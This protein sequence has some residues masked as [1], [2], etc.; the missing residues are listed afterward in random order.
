[1]NVDVRKK[2]E[3][4]REIKPDEVANFEKEWHDNRS[5]LDPRQRVLGRTPLESTQKSLPP[6]RDEGEIQQRL[7]DS[8]RGTNREERRG[9]ERNL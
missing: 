3:N 8:N 2:T 1:M 5:K 6:S 7:D 4:L 9:D